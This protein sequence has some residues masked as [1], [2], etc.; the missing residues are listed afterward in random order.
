MNP[1]I[2]TRPPLCHHL[3]GNYPLELE[4]HPAWPQIKS[5]IKAANPF[6]FP[7]V[8][9]PGL[10]AHASAPTHPAVSGID[11]EYNHSP[12]DLAFYAF[13]NSPTV[14]HSIPTTQAHLAVLILTSEC[15]DGD[16]IVITRRKIQNF[17]DINDHEKK[18]IYFFAGDNEN[19]SF[20]PEC[21]FTLGLFLAFEDH[22][23]MC[24]VIPLVEPQFLMHDILLKASYSKEYFR[25][26]DKDGTLQNTLGE[27]DA[28]VWS[29]SLESLSSDEA[30]S[31]QRK[32]EYRKREIKEYL[33]RGS[34]LT[35][36]ELLD[37]F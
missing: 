21:L 30:G 5:S 20:Q 26:F 18:I 27:D 35:Q 37:S 28:V 36:R 2:L 7:S 1:P 6:V 8:C 10:T 4:S 25:P 16:N 24:Q 23:N 32:L 22:P 31:D 12:F 9:L 34:D 33:G 11:L 3:R 14:D 15:L 29:F 17:L 19:K 13:E